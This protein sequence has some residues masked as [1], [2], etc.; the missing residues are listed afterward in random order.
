MV[1]STETIS[2]DYL[3][4]VITKDGSIRALACVTTGLVG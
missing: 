2:T 3:V 1:N 4:R